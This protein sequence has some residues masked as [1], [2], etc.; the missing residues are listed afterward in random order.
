M[1]AELCRTFLAMP[2]ANT[3][4]GNILVE[5]ATVLLQVLSL[6]SCY[7]QLLVAAAVRCLDLCTDSDHVTFVTIVLLLLSTVLVVQ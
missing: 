7:A 4:M 1:L 5:S 6:L 3:S 2:A